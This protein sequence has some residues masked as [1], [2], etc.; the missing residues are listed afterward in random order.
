MKIMVLG[1]GG[2][3]H[4]LAKKIAKSPLCDVVYVSLGNAGTELEDKC[5]NV[6]LKTLDDI[7]DFAKRENIDLTVVGPENYLTDGIVDLFRQ[8]NLKIF[9]P[10]KRAAML[11]GSKAYAKDFMKKYGVKTAEYN[12]FEDYD[13]AREYIEGASMPIVIKADGLAQGKGVVIC[14]TKKEAQDTLYSFMIDDLFKGSGKRVVIEEYLEGVEASIICVTDGKTIKPFISAKDHKRLLDNDEGPN[15]G[16]MGVIAPNKYVTDDVFD[17]FKRDIMDKTLLGIKEENLDYKGFIYFG[18]MITQKGPY[19]LEYNVRFGDPEAQAILPLMKSD[20]VEVILNTLDGKLQDINIEWMDGASC[21]V[22][23]AAEGY[24]SNVVIGDE[25]FGIDKVKEADVYIAGAEI[26]DG[27]ILTKGGR[28]M[29]VT[30][31]GNTLDEARS[32][33]YSEIEKIKFRGMQYRKD[34][35]E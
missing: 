14:Q 16:G 21:N 25:I 1:S 12:V 18:I 4:A 24:P 32:K 29:S 2:R 28:V 11:E 5:K 6:S 35:G 22:V 15:T 23:L 20:L 30:A 19:L 17:V 13:A 10:D 31:T 34:I 26:K 3:E 33:A 7:V 9:G 27:R 8:N